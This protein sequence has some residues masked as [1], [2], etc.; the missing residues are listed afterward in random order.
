MIPQMV[1]KRVP[2]RMHMSRDFKM[3][4]HRQLRILRQVQKQKLD[5]YIRIAL[6]H[7]EPHYSLSENNKTCQVAW[8]RIEECAQRLEQLDS[9][10]SN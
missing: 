6:S 10:K 8:D 4:Q 9:Q 5:A 3:Q 7:C 2:V 1:V